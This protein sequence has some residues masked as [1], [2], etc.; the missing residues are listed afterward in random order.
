MRTLLLSVLLLPSLLFA[1]V[2]ILMPVVVKDAAGKAVTDLKDSDFK[3]GNKNIRVASVSLIDPQA[4]SNDDARSSV[5]M[6]YDAANMPTTTFDLNVSDL[7]DFLSEIAHRRLAVT[8]LVNTESGIRLIYSART[9]PEVLSAALSATSDNKSKE[10]QVAPP[11][12]DPKVEQQIKNL[13]LL[14]TAG[15]VRRSRRDAEVDQMN[16]QMAFAHLSQQLRGRKALIWVTLA[17]PV[18]A[19]EIPSYWSGTTTTQVDLPLLPMYEATVE[20][21]NA[22][23]VSVYPFLFTQANPENYGALWNQWIA[24]KQLAESTGGLALRLGQQ[25][26]LLAAVDTTFS[27]F[28][29]YYMLVVEVPPAKSLDWIPVKITVDRPGLTVRAAPGY[30]G[31][32]PLKTK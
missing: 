21:L 31:L 7:R 26:S 6:I 8:L 11:V 27:D 23:H 5:V 12:T 14:N 18:S 17:S 20:E 24:L 13:Q 2:K 30:L 25:T 29:P 10:K 3:V 19:T 4:L 9:S 22:A 32:K 15:L 1:Q 28:G 16:S